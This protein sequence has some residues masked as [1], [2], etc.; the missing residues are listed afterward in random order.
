MT[1]YQLFASL[2]AILGF[3]GLVIY[4]LWRHKR[5]PSQIVQAIVG[6]IESKGKALPV[7]DQRLTARQAFK[8]INTHQEF[9]TLLS[10]DDY[11]LLWKVA[12]QEERQTYIVMIL[13]IV[14]AGLSAW[15]HLYIV[16]E[17]RKL[18]PLTDLLTSFEV[19]IDANESRILEYTKDL[20]DSLKS[21]IEQY[22]SFED[23]PILAHEGVLFQ[24]LFDP[25]L[26]KKVEN[27]ITVMPSS[28]YLPTTNSSANELLNGV[29]VGVQVYKPA[30][31]AGQWQN[32]KDKDRSPVME[33]HEVRGT[34]AT[35]SGM[36]IVY[37][38]QRNWLG[39][40]GLKIEQNDFKRSGKLAS[41]QDL[42]GSTIVLWPMWGDEPPKHYFVHEYTLY[43]KAG[44]EINLTSEDF[45]FVQRYNGI[46]TQSAFIAQ[47]KN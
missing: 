2:P 7:M 20:L 26:P 6:I 19:V 42:V 33:V 31:T 45:E 47:I 36:S 43:S 9:R 4:I 38:L 32:F 21:T 13:L 39:Q 10:S 35:W 44:P 34:T 28:A 1:I 22:E 30:L 17:E 3:A 46:I 37:Y 24:S 15:L 12:K 25:S 27:M 16:S 29:I 14:L 40:R 41:W 8:L 5:P 23:I 11:Q 18:R